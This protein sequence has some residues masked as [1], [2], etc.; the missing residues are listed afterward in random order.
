[1]RQAK[2]ERPLAFAQAWSGVALWWC[3]VAALMIIVNASGSAKEM[4]PTRSPLHP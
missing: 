3:A 2:N 1:M 4:A